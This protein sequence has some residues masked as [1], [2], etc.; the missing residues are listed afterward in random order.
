MES[1]PGAGSL[2]PEHLLPAWRG[3]GL[4][5]GADTGGCAGTHAAPPRH[6]APR[7]AVPHRAARHPLQPDPGAPAPHGPRE[8]HPS[9]RSTCAHPL[10]CVPT[11]H[12]SLPVPCCGHGSRV[13]A[14][15]QHA[16]PSP[17]TRTCCCGAEFVSELLYIKAGT[18]GALDKCKQN[19][20]LK[21]L[22]V[23][24]ACISSCYFLMTCFTMCGLG[25]D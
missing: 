13:R 1:W 24:G 6:A 21:P 14:G 12:P 18:A 11:A 7:R 20:F 25:P 17:V 2:C 22:V 19:L 4:H 9:A 15:V 8:T 10:V 16:Q 3:A 23:T 5:A